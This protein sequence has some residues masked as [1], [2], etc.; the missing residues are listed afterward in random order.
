MKKLCIIGNN[1]NGLYNSL[2]YIDDDNIKVDII[3][4]RL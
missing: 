2:K 4:K 1:L 3:V